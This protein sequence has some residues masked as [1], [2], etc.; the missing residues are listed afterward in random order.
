MNKITIYLLA[1][2]TMVNSCSSCKKNT[3]DSNGLPAATQTGANTF[4]F[5]LNGQ[6]W[7]PQGNN[8]TANLSLY[9]D[10]TF[11]GG[12]FNLSAYRNT[13]TTNGSRQSIVIYGDT[14]Q[15]PLKIILPNKN[16]FGLNYWNE[17]KG[18]SYDTSD[19]TTKILSGFFD[20]QKIDKLNH[21]FSG[22]FEIIFT[23]NVCDTIKITSGR[24][25]LKF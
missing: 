4:G 13:S 17:L 24:F 3:T 21:I 19:S 8:G 14:I 11:S 5:L 16:K 10:A 20:I 23:N 7:T 22:Q 15:T 12:V 1:I 25:D 18:C 6:P 2:I 9:Y